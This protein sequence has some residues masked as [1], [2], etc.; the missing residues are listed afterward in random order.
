[1]TRGRRCRCRNYALDTGITFSNWSAHRAH[2][3]ALRAFINIFMSTQEKRKLFSAGEWLTLA[4]MGLS[5][6]SA[7]LIWGTASPEVLAPGAVSAVYRSRF[8]RT[9]AGFD[10]QIGFMRVGWV[11]VICAVICGAMLL[12]DPGAREKKVF[13]V[14]QCCLAAAVLGLAALHAGLYPGVIL[15]GAGGALL[16]WGAILRYR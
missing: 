15:A 2:F 9:E 4:G 5:V 16:L 3:G 6:L 14:L 13:L 11:V 8:T 10:I 7:A 12:F 1:M